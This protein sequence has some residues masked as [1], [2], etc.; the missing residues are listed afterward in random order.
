M[1]KKSSLSSNSL[2]ALPECE[3]DV[4]LEKSADVTARPVAS[5]NEMPY[6]RIK[7]RTLQDLESRVFE[8][9]LSS[10]FDFNVILS[11]NVHSHG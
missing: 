4:Y 3:R 6:Y 5:G 2:G 10:P 8:P 7:V 11:E 9:R 1:S